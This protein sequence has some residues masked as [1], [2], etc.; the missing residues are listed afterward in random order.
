MNLTNSGSGSL[1]MAHNTWLS[2]LIQML[3]HGISNVNVWTFSPSQ[4]NTCIVLASNSFWAL[5]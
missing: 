3:V 4:L 1:A 5:A 2:E